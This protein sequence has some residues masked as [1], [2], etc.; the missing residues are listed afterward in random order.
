MADNT[1]SVVRQQHTR[2]IEFCFCCLYGDISGTSAPYDSA[3]SVILRVNPRIDDVDR[4]HFRLFYLTTW[5]WSCKSEKMY[6]FQRLSSLLQPCSRQQLH[7]PMKIWNLTT[8][9][10][11]CHLKSSVYPGSSIFHGK[12][13]CQI[14]PSFTIIISFTKIFFSNLL[15][16]Y[17]DTS[18]KLLHQN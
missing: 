1:T 4:D 5:T 13:Q 11:P 14:I 9:S 10:R 7:T 2:M 16:I 3:D 8:Y 6:R 15:A 12:C 18:N 17:C